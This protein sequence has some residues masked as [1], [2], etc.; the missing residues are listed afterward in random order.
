MNKKKLIFASVFIAIA[1]ILSAPSIIQSMEYLIYG[2]PMSFGLTELDYSMV[3]EKRWT[4]KPSDF[5]LNKLSS[6]RLA[7]Y[8]AS[9]RT[10]GK[11]KDPNIAADVQRI[12]NDKVKQNDLYRSSGLLNLLFILDKKRAEEFSINIL[13]SN[14][15]GKLAGEPMLYHTALTYLAKNEC[16]SVYPYLVELAHSSEN[17]KK[18]SV[19]LLKGLGKSESVTLLE[20]MMKDPQATQYDKKEILGAI[21]SIKEK[22]NIPT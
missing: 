7:F 21:Q 6:P 11:Q 5:L 18:G 19:F 12:L 1:L 22:N 15:G 8:D 10:L 13:Q 4:S 17:F 14:K 9:V 16:D 2:N 20:E 3:L